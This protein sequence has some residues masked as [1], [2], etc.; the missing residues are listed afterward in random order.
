MASRNDIL[1][2][3]QKNQLIDL[4]KRLGLTGLG[5]KK[6]QA[7]ADTLARKRSLTTKQ[8]LESLR[9][10]DLKAICQTLG[11]AGAGRRKSTMIDALLQHSPNTDRT[12]R[13]RRKSPVRGK[14][15]STSS[16]GTPRQSKALSSIRRGIRY[17]DLVAAES[18][19]S[20]VLDDEPRPVWVML[21]NRNGGTFDDVVVG[22][23][24][25]VVWKQVKWSQ[26][27]TAEPLTIRALAAVGAKRR[28]PLIKSFATSHRRIVAKGTPFR[29]D[30]V[31]NRALDSD[32][33]QIVAGPTSRIKDKNKLKKKSID[34]LEKSWRSLTEFNKDEFWTFLRTLRFQVNSPDLTQFSQSTKRI[35][36]FAG[37]DDGA[38]DRLMDAISDWSKDDGKLQIF[39]SDVEP[40]L[41][42]PVSL[43]PNEFLLPENRVSRIE[44][45]RELERRIESLK[46]GYLPVLGAPGSG[47]STLLNSFFDERENRNGYDVILYNCFTGTSDQF[48]RT[49]ALASNFS[50]Y[51]A[52]KCY[53]Q[54]G[55]Q[56]GPCFNAGD[57]GIETL[58][59][60]AA[61]CLKKGRKLVVIVDGVDYARR[62]AADDSTSLFNSFPVNLP[63]GIVFVISA[64]VLEQFPN[65]LRQDRTLT[66]FE[67]PPLDG[68]QIRDLLR[69]FGVFQ[70][71]ALAPREEDELSFAVLA[72]SKG[73]ALHSS[74]I[75]SQLRAMLSEDARPMDVVEQIPPYDGDIDRYYASVLEMPTNALARDALGLLASSPFELSS[76]EIAQILEPPADPRYVEDL[77]SGHAY[78]F[79]QVGRFW[80]F[81]HDSL[82]SFSLRQ[83][84]A[85]RFDSDSQI[86]FLSGLGE[87]PRLGEHLLHLLAEA[88]P[89]IRSQPEINCDWIVEQSCCGG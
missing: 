39:R 61:A 89:A 41:K 67:V 84:D 34:L 60:R 57:V 4:G 37:C 77:L 53:D 81:S 51:F 19:V 80:H 2:S 46:G 25:L 9:C 40:I 75:A 62:F 44:T 38:Y 27:P 58:V 71:A 82:R 72:K 17:Q 1:G 68:E 3:L 22:F 18:L 14:D 24:N 33:Q 20:M 86:D 49:R 85:A 56:F 66:S 35:L 7:I 52:R 55:S 45:Y 26:N 42:S 13:K 74:F 5:S 63:E 78:L 12:K 48:L 8:L 23:H 15:K 79:R 30:F 32:F 29:L 50:R 43:P 70:N 64:R 6:K 65:H 16:D 73:H 83:S 11:I 47:K 28:T 36:K 31:T 76:R 21:E 88:S 87:D 10:E 59:R 69:Q 54:F